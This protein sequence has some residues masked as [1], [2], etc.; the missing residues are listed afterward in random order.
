[1]HGAIYDCEPG[2]ISV[3]GESVLPYF[4]KFKILSRCQSSNMHF[5]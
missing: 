1:M 5:L 2:T 4:L 3:P